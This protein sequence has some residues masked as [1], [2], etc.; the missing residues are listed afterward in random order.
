MGEARRD[1]CEAWRRDKR[2][3]QLLA[4]EESLY[5]CIVIEGEDIHLCLVED[6]C[7]TWKCVRPDKST[8][9]P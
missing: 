3:Y 1:R 8:G 9:S 7:H 6:K 4:S 5:G 2:N